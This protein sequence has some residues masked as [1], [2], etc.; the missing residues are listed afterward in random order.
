MPDS[1]DEGKQED[2]PEDLQQSPPQR[3]ETKLK[4]D[5]DLGQAIRRAIHLADTQLL[6]DILD[7][8]KDMATH[9]IDQ[10]KQTQVIHL[11]C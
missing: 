11:A 5:E 10:S 3:R 2:K 1:E 9:S 7:K 4:M 6:E 8:D